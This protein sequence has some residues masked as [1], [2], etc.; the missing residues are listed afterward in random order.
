M[1]K[2]PFGLILLL[3]VSS[4]SGETITATCYGPSGKRFDFVDDEASE[5][6]DGFSNSDPT[7]FYSTNDPD[8]LIESWQ[9]ALPFPDLIGRE[10]VDDITPPSVTKSVVVYRS[11]DVIHALSLQGREAY[12]TTLYLN[13]GV[14]IFT[15]IR[16]AEGGLISAPMGAIYTANCNFSVLP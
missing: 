4:A 10:Q 14:G 11:S 2:S 7:F 6:E 3:I 5:S 12:T 8:F 1:N 15:R 9:A 13:R 16:V